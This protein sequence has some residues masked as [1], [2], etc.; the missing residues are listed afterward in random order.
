MVTGVKRFRSPLT[1][2][3]RTAVEPVSLVRGTDVREGRERRS[4][5][6]PT[7][8]EYKGGRHVTNE[9]QGRNQPKR[10]TRDSRTVTSTSRDHAPG[11]DGSG[12][13]LRPV[14][15]QNLWCVHGCCSCKYRDRV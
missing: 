2:R 15:E 13:P 3:S 14:R 11:E 5:P 9:D 6:T 10:E 4:D 1:V 12:E 7:T 8:C